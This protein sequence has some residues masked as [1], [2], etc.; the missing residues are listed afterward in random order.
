M[1]MRHWKYVISMPSH[2]ID[3]KWMWSMTSTCQMQMS[4]YVWKQGFKRMMQNILQKYLVCVGFRNDAEKMSIQRPPYGITVYYKSQ[5]LME[6]ALVIANMSAVEILVYKIKLKSCSSIKV[7][8]VYKPPA[9][10]L[11][12]ISIR[13]ILLP[14]KTVKKI[15]SW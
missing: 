4:C 1:W 15:S 14:G 7:M 11:Q 2:Y 13:C 12:C 10:L 9:V 8:A 3:T 6:Q 5:H